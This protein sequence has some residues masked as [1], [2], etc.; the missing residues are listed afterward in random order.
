ME[1]SNRRPG[2]LV[3]GDVPRDWRH[4]EAN[5]Q[6]RMTKACKRPG[7]EQSFQPRAGNQRYCS[8][9]CKRWV[10]NHSPAHL[11]AKERHD[12][13]RRSSGLKAAQDARWYAS[14]G[15]YR[16]AK[17]RLARQL[18]EHLELREQLRREAASYPSEERDANG[19]IWM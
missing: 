12:L 19:L 3:S 10:S 18:A 13:R 17:A 15:W 16:Q 1:P 14:G 11:A 7:C 6:S 4:R 8:L 2:E 9:A 5:E